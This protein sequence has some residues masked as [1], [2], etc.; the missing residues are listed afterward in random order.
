MLTNNVKILSAAVALA[1]LGGCA[2]GGGGGNRTGGGTTINGQRATLQEALAC[3]FSFGMA[4]PR[5]EQDSSAGE[6]SK[7]GTLYGQPVE[8]VPLR[9]LFSGDPGYSGPLSPGD[10]G[11]GAPEYLGETGDRAKVFSP[12]TSWA[13]LRS[14]QAAEASG[15]YV[16]V[17]Y[18]SPIVITPGVNELNPYWGYKGDIDL[19]GEP[20]TNNGQSVASRIQ[21]DSEG[22]LRQFNKFVE[23]NAFTDL[24]AVGQP[25]IDVARDRITNGY[26]VTSFTSTSGY[27]IGLVANPHILGWNYQ[28]FGVWDSRVSDEGHITANSFGA[29]TPASAVPTTGSANFTGK[30]TGFYVAPSGQGSVAAANVTATANF[31]TRSIGFASSGTTLTRDLSQSTSAPSLD[32]NGT[33]TYSP[34]SNSFTGTLRN[35]GGTMSGVSNGKFYGPAAQELGGVFAVKS[36]TSVEAFTGAYGAKR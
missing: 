13:E 18:D 29:A 8:C 36:P 17:S 15:P 30:L 2:S 26:P 28:S 10:P 35:A 22:K 3:V 1:L 6:T 5:P 32:L 34:G 24:A 9:P 11:Y 20:W 25:G 12:F 4:C 31:S 23:N 33:L 27:E 14:D 21:Y 7:C 19:V 16:S